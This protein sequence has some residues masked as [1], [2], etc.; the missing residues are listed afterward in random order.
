MD[1]VEGMFSPFMMYRKG[2]RLDDAFVKTYSDSDLVMRMHEKGLRCYR[3]CGLFVHHLA[4]MTT[5]RVEPEKHQRDLAQDE[6]LF[7]RRWGKNR[8]LLF[9]M[10]RS[11]QVQ[12][13]RE[14]LSFTT[15]INLHYDPNKPEG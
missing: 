8:S 3:S 2:W 9:G 6:R 12:Y 1:E 11:G 13:G 15:P 10:I 5:D 14:H 7:Y 4:R